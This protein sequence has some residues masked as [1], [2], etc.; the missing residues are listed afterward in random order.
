MKILTIWNMPWVITKIVDWYSERQACHHCAIQL[1]NM[2][3]E[4]TVPRVRKVPVNEYKEWLNKISHNWRYCL[5]RERLI[6]KE[7]V[8]KDDPILEVERYLG[9][10][11]SLKVYLKDRPDRMN[12]SKYVATILQACGYI[13][14]KEPHKYRPIDIEEFLLGGY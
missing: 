12:C 10:K 8:L 11:Y 3:Y 1:G 6:V 4:S 14:D 9:M 2:I 13:L 7:W 5:G